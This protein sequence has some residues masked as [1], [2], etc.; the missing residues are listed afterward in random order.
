M[1]HSNHT[2]HLEDFKKRFIVSLILTIPVLL[3]S[4]MIWDWFGFRLDIA[5]RKEIIFIL[6][7]IIYFYGGKPFLLGSLHEIKQKNPGMMTL[8][9]MAI[10]VAYIY[11]TYA[12]FLENAKEFFWE[13][14][15]LIDI[16]LI[17]H[18][19]ESKSVAGA[20][21]ALQSLVQLIPKKAHVIQDNKM[22]DI[23]IGQLKPGDIILVKPGEKIPIDGT[24]LEGEALVD[25]SFLSGESKPV[26]KRKNSHVY[27]GS[28]NLDS[29]LKIIV[30]KPGGKSYL[31]QV[32]NL[33]K[34]A[35]MSR[36]KLQDTANKAAK[37]LFFIALF[38]GGS[39]FIYWMPI[40]SANE[41]LLI[42]V[43]VLIIACPHALGLAV[44]LVVAIS[45]TK[46]A[47]YGILIRNREA[48]E[49][50]RNIDAICFDKTG[51]LT[52]GKL[53]VK[54]IVA[55]DPKK[56]LAFS[57]SLEK[58][59]EHSIAK[60]IVEEAKKAKLPLLSVDKF[61]I[62]PG[63][64]A[65]GLIKGEKVVIGNDTA[66]TEQGF[67]LPEQNSDEVGTKV[68]VGVGKKILGYI[69][70]MDTIRTE[71]KKAIALL[72]S[73]HIE[74]V[75]LTGDN[76]ITAKAVADELQMKR[77]FAHLLPDQKVAI[78]EELKKSGKKVAMVGDGINDA[79]SLLSANVG[80][81]IGAGTDIA[82]QSA[83]IILTNNSIFDIA[84]AIA[85]SYATYSK[86]IQN[87]WWASGYNIIAI[88]LA[89]GVARGV[90]V[91]ITPEIGALMMSLSTV[92]VAINAQF[93]KRFRFDE[94]TA[95][96]R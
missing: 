24:V 42:S 45:T 74:T 67:E 28:T 11:S 68:W 79:P 84:K 3:L 27:M 96:G 16:M 15:T 54:N 72:H 76:E 37:W 38:A 55:D 91:A 39:T 53:K 86:I 7:S 57:A 43:T 90:G 92:I 33:V 89:A 29:S 1:H 80:I 77:Y 88:P 19:I 40:L 85:L 82:A 87:L 31:Y 13:L 64:G 59:S 17:G 47:H 36:S 51:T 48:F 78:I 21:Q 22:K 23:S 93:L 75:M 52:E 81:A 25:E 62:I 20:S 4:P 2:H 56:L 73:M 9:A 10:S 49:N 70:L 30:Q 41:A 44:P 32:I 50:L 35:Q 12:L 71:T 69:L 83:D 14:A 5:F 18:Y 58:L 61:K 26:S 34:E 46:A 95:F 8:I 65:L 63:K 94:N 6:S 66:L 60:A